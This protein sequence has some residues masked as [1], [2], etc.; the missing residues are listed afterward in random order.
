MI[1]QAGIRHQRRGRGMERG[2]GGKLWDNEAARRFAAH[3]ATAGTGLAAARVSSEGCRAVLR[4][5][6]TH[7]FAINASMQSNAARGF[8]GACSSSSSAAS[9]ARRGVSRRRADNED[10]RTVSTPVDP[11]AQGR[12]SRAVPG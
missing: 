2:G 11:V 6:L 8:A 9:R 7:F 1:A 5:G 10:T 3:W 4:E 12:R